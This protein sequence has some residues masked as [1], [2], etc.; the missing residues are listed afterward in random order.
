MENSHEHRGG[1]VPP[2]GGLVRPSI[3]VPLLPEDLTDIVN[4]LWGTLT[5]RTAVKENRQGAYH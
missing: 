1:N 3:P 2:F 5:M 4:I